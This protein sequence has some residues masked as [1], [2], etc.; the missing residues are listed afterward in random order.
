MPTKNIKNVVKENEET[1]FVKNVL[2]AWGKN[3]IVVNVPASK[4]I[5]SI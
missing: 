4:P 3:E 1:S 5:I 2:Y